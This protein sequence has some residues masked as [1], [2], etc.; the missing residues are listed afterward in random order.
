RQR[1]LGPEH[2]HTLNSRTNLEAA[3]AAMR[4]GNGRRMRWLSVMRRRAR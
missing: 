1:V 2:P 4:R 3:L